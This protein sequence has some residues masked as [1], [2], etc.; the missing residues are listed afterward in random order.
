[1]PKFVLEQG[2]ALE[3]TYPY[4]HALSEMQR[5]LSDE[6]NKLKAAVQY[7]PTK[8]KHEIKV[9]EAAMSQDQ[10]RYEEEQ[11]AAQEEFVTTVKNLET[12]IE[13]LSELTDM[14]ETEEYASRV[15]D[16][17]LQLKDAQAHAAV[18]NRRESIFGKRP[19]DYSKIRRAFE[20]FDPFNKF[21]VYAR[22]WKSWKVGWTEC[23]FAELDATEMEQKVADAF[24]VMFKMGKQ[25]VSKKLPTYAA[26]CE[27]IR[28]ELDAF[29]KYIP[30]S[31]ALRSPGM[32]DRHWE[33][34]AEDVGVRVPHDD[35]EF[36]LGKL[37][38]M[39]VFAPEKA[40][41]IVKVCDVAGK[42]YG[43][44]TAIKKMKDEWDGA[45][46]EVKEY[47]ETETYVIR[48]DEAITQMLDDH[49][50]M[51]QA[52]TFSPYKKP[53][54]EEILEWERTLSMV[55]EVLDE[56]MNVQRAWMYLEPIFGSD[57]IMEQLPLEGE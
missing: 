27:T 3:D 48:V 33:Q 26:N 20:D 36:N 5:N 18:F 45:D 21:W 19:T 53:F 8:L 37:I 15:V 47:R 42:E 22:D 55:S 34:I 28:L 24:K 13:G 1:M 31:L 9:T 50:V 12:V 6:D 14:A 35:P 11:T 16:I 32:R 38:E 25:F 57:D 41:E 52:M 4:Y 30:L 54:E 10:M 29:Q 39:G 2:F 40:D 23:P 46:L 43:I 7:W 51:A 44:E 49:I 17:D 56:W